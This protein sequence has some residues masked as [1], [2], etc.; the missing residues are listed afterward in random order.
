M[1]RIIPLLVLS[2]L[3]LATQARKLSYKPVY[4]PAPK[5]EKVADADSLATLGIDIDN[6][7]VFTG[8][9]KQQ[10]AAKEIFFVTNNSALDVKRLYLEI[11]YTDMNGN[12]LHK[13]NEKVDL[14]LSSGSRMLITLPTWDTARHFR[15]HKSAATPRRSSIPYTVTIRLTSLQFG[16]SSSQP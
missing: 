8:Y 3:V 5:T 4:Q 2:L 9:D 10:T 14:D 1:K 15:Y 16:P 6:D 7:F 13:R 11:V 12:A